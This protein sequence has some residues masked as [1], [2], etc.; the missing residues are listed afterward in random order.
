MYAQ[1][2]L[3]KISKL[4]YIHTFGSGWSTQR[5]KKR[6]DVG[7]V[8][9]PHTTKSLS[10]P[11]SNPHHY[12]SLLWA[13]STKKS[14][15]MPPALAFFLNK[16]LFFLMNIWMSSPQLFFYDRNSWCSWLVFQW[17]Y[18]ICR[19]LILINTSV[20]NDSWIV[21]I[22]CSLPPRYFKVSCSLFVICSEN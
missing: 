15:I 17:T 5:G 20:W 10:Q 8:Y 19:L 13:D 7:I 16:I 2:Q 11:E 3:K 21:L 1:R 9:T 14:T 12:L 4:A 6:I 22:H 18:L